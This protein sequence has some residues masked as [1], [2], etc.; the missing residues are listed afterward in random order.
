VSSGVRHIGIWPLGLGNFGLINLHS[1]KRTTLLSFPIWNVLRG[2]RCRAHGHPDCRL[3]FLE[4]RSRLCFPEM[5]YSRWRNRTVAHF[6]NGRFMEAPF[7]A[8]TARYG[9]PAALTERTSAFSRRSPE[10]RLAASH[11]RSANWAPAPSNERSAVYKIRWPKRP[12]RYP[13]MAVEPDVLPPP[14]PRNRAR[15][16]DR[17]N[18]DFNGISDLLPV[19]VAGPRGQTVALGKCQAETIAKAKPRLG[20]RRS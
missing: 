10:S 16:A 15:L 1:A 8:R 17:D 18:L 20:C 12:G 9:P 11:Q 14:L 7:I 5:P 2:G 19:L 6:R 13:P 4:T 3:G